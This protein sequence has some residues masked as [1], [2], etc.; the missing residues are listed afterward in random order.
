MIRNFCAWKGRKVTY[1]EISRFAEDVGLVLRQCQTLP[2]NY[3]KMSD[4][5]LEHLISDLC[6]EIMYSRLMDSTDQ[7]NSELQDKL[8]VLQN[9]ITPKMLNIKDEHFAYNVY[10]LSFNELRKINSVKS[11]RHK[12]RVIFE[13]INCLS[14][15]FYA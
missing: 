10:Q 7:K 9:I 1:Y 15:I 5:N 13:S 12:C 3:Q 6:Y 2:S 11:P 14:S 8:F 4:E